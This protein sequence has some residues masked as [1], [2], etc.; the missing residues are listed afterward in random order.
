[1]E[2]LVLSISVA[3]IPPNPNSTTVAARSKHFKFVFTILL[4][5]EVMF[6]DRIVPTSHTSMSLFFSPP[7]GF[8]IIAQ[9]RRLWLK[10]LLQSSNSTTTPPSLLRWYQLVNSTQ[11]RPTTN[12]T[13]RKEGSVLVKETHPSSGVMANCALMEKTRRRDGY[14]LCTSAKGKKPPCV[15]LLRS[16]GCIFRRFVDCLFN[17]VDEERFFHDAQEGLLPSCGEVVIEKKN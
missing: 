2:E 12:N 8:T 17:Y 6:V 15:G 11:P 9:S 1:M 13:L 5:D 3:T 16:L 4:G 14:G 10:P 7:E